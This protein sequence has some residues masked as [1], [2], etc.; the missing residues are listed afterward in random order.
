MS[1]SPEGYLDY[2]RRGGGADLSNRVKLRFTGADRVRYLNGQLTADI[3]KLAS[4]QSVPACV[5]TAKGKLCADVVVTAQPE[6]LLVDADETLQEVLLPRFER[7]IIADDV[8]VEDVTTSLKLLH[9]L[10]PPS[11]ASEWPET[12]DF[13]AMGATAARRFGRLGFDFFLP[14]DVS[15]EM[16]TR[17]AD[18]HALLEEGLLEILRI[19]AGIP[20]WGRELTEATLPPEAGLDRT[21]IDYHKGC[22]IGQEVISRIKS[23]GHVNRRLCGFVSVAGTPLTAGSQLAIPGDESG[24]VGSLTSSTQS[25]ALEKEIALGYLKRGS[26]TGE[27]LARPADATGAEAVVAV[28]ELPFL[29]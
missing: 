14:E 15:K 23:V 25:F 1:A 22:Y 18:G 9:F 16:W 4:G 2:R 27:L 26:P 17:L 28:R 19:E 20:R 29:S 7:Y 6:A 12:T 10:P 21:H 13:R 8:E 3:R 11:E 24:P 5:L